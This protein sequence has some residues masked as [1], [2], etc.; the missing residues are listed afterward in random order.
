MTKIYIPVENVSDY[1]CYELINQDTIRVY[2]DTPVYNQNIRH[3]DIYINSHYLESN[4]STTWY[5]Y[6]NESSKSNLP[7]CINT[8]NITN[9]VEYSNDFCDSLIITFILL[10][11]CFYFPYKFII[12]KLFGRWL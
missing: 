2:L 5:W 9:K 6:N 11:I 4:V 1:K 3:K 8:D 12:K 7:V 10:I